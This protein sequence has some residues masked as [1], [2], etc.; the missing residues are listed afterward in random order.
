MR[1]ATLQFSPRLGEVAANF[2]RAESLLMR[3]ER[4]GMLENLD[5]LVLPE[6]AF[7]GYNHPSL[8]AIAPFLEPTAAG[9]STRWAART[10]KRLKCT[11]AVGYAEA[12]EEGNY[13]TIFDRHITAE[14]GTVAY[15]SLVFVNSAG[16]V[17]AHHRKAFLYYTDETWAQEGQGFWAGVLPIGGKGD[18]VKAA[19]G[20]C[21]DINPYRFE[22]PWTTYEFANHAREARAKIVVISMAWL[23]RLSAEEVSSEPMAPDQDTVNYWVERLR[24]LFGAQGAESEAIVVC[25]NRAGEEGICPRIGEVRYAGSSCVMGM[26]K[27]HHIRIWDILGRA[28]EGVLVVDTTSPPAYSVVTKPRDQEQAE[29]DEA[30]DLRTG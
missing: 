11:V 23:T 3:E 22:A 24:P 17:V 8:D 4:E 12:A 10:A 1:I 2:S 18:Q 15:N 13:N 21:M 14:A 28:Q 27:G 6:L 7:A 26:T 5:L 16:D 29:T 20:I 30:A 19:A 25:A 9:P